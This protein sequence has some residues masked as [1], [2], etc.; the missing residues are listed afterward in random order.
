MHNTLA[1]R[2]RIYATIAF[3]IT[4]VAAHAPMIVTGPDFDVLIE[5]YQDD[6]VLL[7]TLKWMKER[8]GS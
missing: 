8:Y 4:N 7:P 3:N 1:G 2:G 5:E 6:P